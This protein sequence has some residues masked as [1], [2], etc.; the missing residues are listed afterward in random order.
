VIVNLQ[1]DPELR[2]LYL[3]TDL[4]MAVVVFKKTTVGQYLLVCAAMDRSDALAELVDVERLMTDTLCVAPTFGKWQLN[5]LQA[6]DT[7]QCSPEFS[8]HNFVPHDY[9]DGRGNVQRMV[10]MTKDGF[11]MLV[12]GFTGEAA[13]AFKEAYIAA[14]NALAAYVATHQQSL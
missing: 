10:K 9:I 14:F 1:Q 6:Y 13:M 8:R 4:Q 7:L 3:A 12:M 2:E 11:I 5:T